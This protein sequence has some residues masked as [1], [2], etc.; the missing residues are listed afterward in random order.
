M[1]IRIQPSGGSFRGAGQYYLH[2]KSDDAELDNAL[3][4]QTAERIWFT[5]T[6]NCMNNDP[7]RAL[8]EMWGVA[9]DTGESHMTLGTAG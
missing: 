7:F 8:D 2:D 3:K 1:I 6:R 5:E 4:P 9:E